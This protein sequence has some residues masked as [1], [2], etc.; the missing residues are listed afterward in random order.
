M[1]PGPG[2]ASLPAEALRFRLGSPPR[3][4]GEYRISA[5]GRGSV[6]RAEERHTDIYMIRNYGELL[7]SK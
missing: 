7:T 5:D 6:A 1:D 3:V 4:P 2:I